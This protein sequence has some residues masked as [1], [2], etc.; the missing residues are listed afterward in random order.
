[1]FYEDE[2]AANPGKK[3]EDAK[4]RRLRYKL[5]REKEAK[6]ARKL[7]AHL[8]T[9]DQ[10]INANVPILAGKSNLYSHNI[11]HV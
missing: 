3:K 9:S 11:S 6:R 7:S 5:D 2:K 8:T 4:K 1:M 10:D